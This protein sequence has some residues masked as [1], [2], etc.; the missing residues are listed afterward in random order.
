MLILVIGQWSFPGGHLEYGEDFFACAERETLEETG[1]VI[2]GVKIIAVTNDKFTEDNKHYITLFAKC[3]RVDS[4]QQPEVSMI[5][6]YCQP[7]LIMSTGLEA[8]A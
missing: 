7:Q 1:L 2:K 5:L 8:R 6:T 3:V 4:T